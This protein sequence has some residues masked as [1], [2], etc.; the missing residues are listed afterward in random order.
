MI[1]HWEIFKLIYHL[2]IGAALLLLAAV[3]EG[4]GGELYGALV[5]RAS[6]VPEMIEAL[7]CGF[8][9]AVGGA[10]CASYLEHRN[11]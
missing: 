9:L 6:Y 5:G 2:L 7:I 1:K 3:A 10:L 4:S 11:T 8:T